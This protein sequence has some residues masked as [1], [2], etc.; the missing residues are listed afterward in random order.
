MSELIPKHQ[1]KGKPL[2][3]QGGLLSLDQMQFNQPSM[4]RD[5]TV[6]STPK[7]T[8]QILH[9][10]L[11]GKAVTR[12]EGEKQTPGTPMTGSQRIADQLS[13]P[14]PKSV[15]EKMIAGLNTLDR[16]GDNPVAGIVTQPLKSA[17]NTLRPDK[18]FDGVRN[19]NDVM[20][21]VG[22]FAT[23]AAMVVPALEEVGAMRQGLRGTINLADSQFSKVG[24]ALEDVGIQGRAAGLTD[25]QIAANQLDKVGITSQQRKAYLPGISDLVYNRVEPFGY[26]EDFNAL[27]R[28]I[29]GNETKKFSDM[30]VNSG[31]ADM[32]KDLPTRETMR[33]DAWRMYLGK[34][35]RFGTFK[36]V[37]NFI[38]MFQKDP[39][40]Q[41]FSLTNDP[42]KLT[43][44]TRSAFARQD[45]NEAAAKPVGSYTLGTGNSVMGNYDMLRSPYGV[46]YSDVWDLHPKINLGG[47][48]KDV[49]PATGEFAFAGKGRSITVPVSNFIG[50]PFHVNGLSSVYEPTSEPPY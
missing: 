25:Q 37:D 34:P 30:V 6:K 45:Y 23:D 1:R 44:D 22:R 24:R 31:N 38:S 43:T 2:K 47:V 15:R 40:L 12:S 48:A 29:G 39:S 50:K 4:Q 36:P 8:D 16:N 32:Y 5:A 17:L 28:Q 26:P 11:T 42:F 21:G 14:Q 35:Q 10:Y 13:I 46:E 27:K 9:N 41:K 19:D 33:D 3:Q 7:P 20:A 18:Y 49:D